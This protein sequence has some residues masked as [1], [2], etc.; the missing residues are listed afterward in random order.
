MDGHIRAYSTA[1]GI[2]I[3]DFDTL[4]EHATVND[5]AARGGALNGNGPVVAGGMVFVS[6]GYNHFNS[7]TGNVLLAFRPD[8]GGDA[9]R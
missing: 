7:M 2:V 8:A 6:S 3:W 1:N 9:P 4:G 5:I